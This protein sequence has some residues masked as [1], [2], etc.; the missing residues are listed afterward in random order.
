MDLDKIIAWLEREYGN[1]PRLWPGKLEKAFP[2]QGDELHKLISA[3]GG[4]RTANLNRLRMESVD[5][6]KRR[7]LN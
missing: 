6:L 3:R 2:G 4:E 5:D 1:A 7:K